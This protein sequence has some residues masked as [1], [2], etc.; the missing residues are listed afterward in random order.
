MGVCNCCL[1]LELCFLGELGY[2]DANSGGVVALF[3][4]LGVDFID[5]SEIVHGL[6]H[7]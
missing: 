5:F 7:E 6:T 3:E 1:Y 2:C 4:I